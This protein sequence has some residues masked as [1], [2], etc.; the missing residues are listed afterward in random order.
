MTTRK[1]SDHNFKYVAVNCEGDAFASNAPPQF[2]DDGYAVWPFSGFPNRFTT[3]V[4]D[5]V[6]GGELLH[7]RVDRDHWTKIFTY[8]AFMSAYSV[9]NLKHIASQLKG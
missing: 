6:G 4:E 9:K 5:A 2:D 1:K 8:E 3:D 7:S